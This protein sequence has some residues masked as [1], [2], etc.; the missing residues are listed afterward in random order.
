MSVTIEELLVGAERSDPALDFFAKLTV[1]NRRWTHGRNELDG[2]LYLGG[3]IQWNGL[4]A[5]FGFRRFPGDGLNERHGL[6][7]QKI[8]FSLPLHRIPQPP[9]SQQKG[10]RSIKP[11]F[12]PDLRIEHDRRMPVA[13]LQSRRAPAESHRR[14]TRFATSSR[15]NSGRALQLSRGDDAGNGM[16]L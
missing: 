11:R 3:F 7:D 2:S 5:A 9:S 10:R 15:P 4:K 12:L 1:T 13:R 8:A 6:R 16:T 14:F